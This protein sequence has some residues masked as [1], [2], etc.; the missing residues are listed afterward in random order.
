[1][2]KDE[3]ASIITNKIGTSPEETDIT[4]LK[5]LT[6]IVIKVKKLTGVAIG[7]KKTIWTKS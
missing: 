1:M 6:I 7:A 3:I 2:L 5:P 4:P